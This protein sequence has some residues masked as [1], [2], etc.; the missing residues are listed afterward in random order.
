M[1][2]SEECTIIH[3]ILWERP[4]IFMVGYWY[5]SWNVPWHALKN[6]PWTIIYYERDHIYSWR[7]LGYSMKCFMVCSEE[8]TMVHH[9]L[10]ERPYIFMEGY[11]YTPWNVPWHALRNTLWTIIYYERDHIYSWWAIGILHEMFHGVLWRMHH[12]PSYIHGGLL[13]YFMKC[14]MAC[15]EECTMD[16]HILWERPY[17]FMVGYWYTPWHV[18]WRA[19][20]NAPWTV[21]Y[22]WWVIGI[23]HEMFHGILWEMHH[24]PSYIMRETIYLWGAIRKCY[25]VCSGQ[26]TMNHHILWERPYIFLGTIDILHEMFH[27][28]LWEMH[29]GPSY[30]RQTINIYIYKVAMGILHG[31]FHEVH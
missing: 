23:L 16:H 4:Y 8:C 5:T 24:G 31:M 6:A 22:S 7:A 18:P 2:C 3:H 25:M 28:M 1:A 17:I 30:G 27:G 19:L 10:W 13:V 9:I 20:K 21:I 14:S 26:C 12:E 15:S 11:W 29:H